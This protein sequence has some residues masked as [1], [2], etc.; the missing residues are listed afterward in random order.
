MSPRDHIS[1][2]ALRDGSVKHVSTGHNL[3]GTQYRKFLTCDEFL[4]SSNFWRGL[5]RHQRSAHESGQFQTMLATCGGEL[6]TDQF[7]ERMS[8]TDEA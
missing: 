8:R 6:Q 3:A 2:S 5:C 4:A 1:V 7:R